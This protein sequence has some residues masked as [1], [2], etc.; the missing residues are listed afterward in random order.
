MKFRTG[1]TESTFAGNSIILKLKTILPITA[2]VLIVSITNPEYS[3]AQRTKSSQSAGEQRFAEKGLKDN[4]YFF[5]YINA[6]ISN[7]GSEEEKDIFKE[8]IQR[9]ILAQQLY[10]KFLFRESFRE[11]RASQELLVRVY[12]KTIANDIKLARQ[13]L[14]EFAAEVIHSNCDRARLYLRLGYRDTENASIEMI[15]S[16]HFRPTLY[17]MRLYKYIDALKRAKQARRYAFLAITY[18]R[19]DDPAF[20]PGRLSFNEL[21]ELIENI[22]DSP[23]K[24]ELYRTIHL[25]NYYR[26]KDEISFYD[27]IWMNPRLEEIPEY[28]EYLSIN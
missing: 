1:K 21:G 6:S 15:M 2:A 28:E 10:M 20:E 18:I 8:A 27:R 13:L 7:L 11:V 3:E 26:F 5:Y 25:D 4:R 19:A 12:R 9:D 22:P 17:S 16:D 23:D 24:K 14:N